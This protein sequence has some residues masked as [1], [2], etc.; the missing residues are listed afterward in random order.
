MDNA[1]AVIGMAGRFPGARDVEQFWRNLE[2]GAE[3]ITDLTSEQLAA[4]R[5]GAELL[6]R[7][8]YVRRAALLDDIELF[9]AAFF[10]IAQREALVLD[11]QQRLFLESCWQA[12]EHAG[13]V[14]DEYPGAVAVYAG[15]SLNTYLLHNL[16]C[17]PLY[18]TTPEGFQALI[19]ND[20]D[21]LAT[22]VAY[23]LN[24]RG[25]AVTVQTACSTSLAAVH[26]A[27]QSLH[28]GECDM[29]LAGGVSIKIPHT[30]GY[31]HQDGMPF[32]KDGRCR[33]F[34]AASSGTVFGSGVGVVLLKRLD[35]A[36]ADGDNVLAVIRASSMNNDGAMKVGFTAPSG[37]G[38]L[39]VIAQTLNVA[40][41]APETITYVEA[42]GTGTPL[43]DPIEIQALAEAYGAGAQ[44]NRLREDERRTSRDC[45]RRHRPDQDDSDAASRA[46]RPEPALQCGQPTDRIRVHAV[47][48]QS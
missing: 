30:V 31:L 44:R 40:N 12:F 29:A 19:G 25:P 10:G 4:V 14:P 32:A 3:S 45:L 41:V 17:N 20:K 47:L 46:T 5:V 16:A 24:L 26:M 13:Y 36:L 2:A 23:K 8:N 15:A 1:I 38:Q 27:C 21:Y 22:R 37:Q 39:D 43:G 9:D 48:R 34:D 35:D 18:L 7:D 42:H 11:P 28:L 33:A 6:E